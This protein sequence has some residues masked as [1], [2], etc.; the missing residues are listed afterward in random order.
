MPWHSLGEIPS[1]LESVLPGLALEEREEGREE[2]EGGREGGKDL[3]IRI[4]VCI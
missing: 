4:I 1:T 3:V 2:Q